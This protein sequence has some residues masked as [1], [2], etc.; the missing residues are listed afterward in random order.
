[1]IGVPAKIFEP[2]EEMIF[3]QNVFL[4]IIKSG[5]KQLNESLRIL[6]CLIPSGFDSLELV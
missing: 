1:M 4:V 2:V 3:D 5:L 6:W